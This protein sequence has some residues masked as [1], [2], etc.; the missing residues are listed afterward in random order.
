MKCEFCHKADAETA[1]LLETDGEVKEL[2]VCRNCA[3]AAEGAANK[4]DGAHSASDP[5]GPPLPLMG[6]ILDAAFEIVGR[7][8]SMSDLT[9]P[10]CRITRNEYR[11]RSRLGCPACYEAFAKELDAAIFDLHRAQQHVGKAPQQAQADMRR[12][13]IEEALSEAV[14]N[15][16]FEEAIE[17]RDRLRKLDAEKDGEKGQTA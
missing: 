7:A 9:C 17:L 15:Q 10:S 4:A 11:K 8:M 16:H 5:V 2:F 3:A 1:I 14:R 13:T 6:M 12:R